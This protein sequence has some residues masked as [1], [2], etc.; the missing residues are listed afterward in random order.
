VDLLLPPGEH[1]LRRDVTNRAVQADIVVVVDV[2][3][4]QTLGII[5]R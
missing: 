4:Y 1:V 2:L 5:E 3:A